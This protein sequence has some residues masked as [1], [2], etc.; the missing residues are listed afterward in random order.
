MNLQ[1]L[2]HGGVHVVL[3]GILAEEDLHGKGASGDLEDWHVAKKRRE[4][5]GV[6]CGGS[7]DETQVVTSRDHLWAI[8]QC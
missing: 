2:L 6:H 5:P 1:R 4:L 8:I 3:D 7:D